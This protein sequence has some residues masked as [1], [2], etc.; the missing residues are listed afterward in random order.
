[1]HDFI[2]HLFELISQCDQG[3]CKG[4]I[5]QAIYEEMKENVIEASLMDQRLCDL[6]ERIKMVDFSDHAAVIT[7]L[8]ALH[9]LITDYKWE[10]MQ[11]HDEM[12][13]KLMQSPS[14]QDYCHRDQTEQ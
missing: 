4:Q 14:L 10:L 3:L 11:L 5:N 13:V 8:V 6:S 12:L 1:M 7:F 2:K 9:G